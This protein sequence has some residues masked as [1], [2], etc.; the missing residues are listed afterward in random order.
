MRFMV[1]LFD[2]ENGKGLNTMVSAICKLTG[3]ISDILLI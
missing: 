2:F 1:Y 3:F